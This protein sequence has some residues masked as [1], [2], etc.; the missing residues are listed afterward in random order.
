MNGYIPIKALD[1]LFEMVYN[2]T[3]VRNRLVIAVKNDLHYQLKIQA[4]KEGKLLREV[5]EKAIREYLDRQK[6]K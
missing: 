5:T 4:A 2:Y 6:K 1:K 3:T